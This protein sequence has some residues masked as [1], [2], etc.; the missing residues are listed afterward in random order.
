MKILIIIPSM[1]SGGAEHVVADMTA[2]WCKSH[3]I[4]LLTF[5][6]KNKDF[7]KV[8]PLVVR[9]DMEGRKRKIWNLKAQFSIIKKIKSVTK[10]IQPDIV[11]SFIH[12]ANIYSSFALWGSHIPLVLSES[13]LINRSDV[14]VH[15]SL[16]RK[17]L[18]PRAFKLVVLSESI[19]RE[20]LM[21]IP[22]VYETD[23]VAIP[24]P[25]DVSEK[26]DQVEPLNE[27]TGQNLDGKKIIISVGRLIPLKSFDHLIKAIKEVKSKGS[28]FHLVIIGE[29]EE[30]ANLESIIQR[31]DLLECVSLPGR[32]NSVLS[33]LEQADF[34]ISTSQLEGF[35]MAVIESLAVGTP[36]LAYDAPGVRDLIKHGYNGELVP[37]GDIH[38]LSE[39]IIRWLEDEDIC[40]SYIKNTRE[41]VNQY[42]CKNVDSIWE[43][44][45]FELV[46][47]ESK[48]VK[49]I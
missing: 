36:V 13:S 25:I 40:K 21:T 38:L 7:Y 10:N 33:Y 22:K 28:G 20:L 43:T 8:S 19:K 23:V 32:T 16:L 35:G 12:K 14:P 15:I 27:F 42:S 37:Y 3:E 31:E 34:S 30:R 49:K 41:V 9:Y 44:E 11:I 4:H 6:N 24:N 45:V 48:L 1:T 46:V 47:K 17:L 2:R 5:S 29:G 26:K 18:Y 39:R